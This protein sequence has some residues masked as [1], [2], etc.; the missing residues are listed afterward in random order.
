MNL[1]NEKIIE[2][3][4][5][6]I[7][8][9]NE[10]IID[11]YNNYDFKIE[12]KSDNSPLTIAD[13]ES[14]KIIIEGLKKINELLSMNIPIISEE[15]KIIDYKDRQ[16]WEY[17]WLVD[18]LDGTK[19]FIKK[20]GEFTTNIGLVKN[21]KVIFG[22]V[23]IPVQ[24]LIYYGGINIDSVKVNYNNKSIKIK[25]NE[26]YSKVF[27]IVAS[28]SHMNDDTKKLIEKLD[29]KN[30]QLVSYGSSLKILKVADGSADYYPR[31]APTMEWDTCAA[32]G[33]L[34]GC[35]SNILRINDNKELIYNKENLLNPYFH[36]KI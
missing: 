3:L 27:N 32:H 1:I 35:N 30:K 6:I 10:K 8:L 25:T 9:A 16:K 23:G 15:N 36:T 11:I 33:V 4:K 22:I 5:I 26:N 19:E 13:K 7:E 24:N 17:C 21:N 34:K 14:N 29:Y 31:V 2:H 18:P 20:N 12:I 28:K